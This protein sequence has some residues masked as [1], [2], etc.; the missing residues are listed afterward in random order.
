MTQKILYF[1]ISLAAGIS[2]C[3]EDDFTDLNSFHA[4][5]QSI[6]FG[7]PFRNEKEE[8]INYIFVTDEDIPGLGTIQKSIQCLSEKIAE[9]VPN[10]IVSPLGLTTKEL[11]FLDQLAYGHFVLDK[12]L[13]E[14]CASEALEAAMVHSSF[15][16]D[17]FYN[18]FFEN[19][20]KSD[21]TIIIINAHGEGFPY[22]AGEFQVGDSNFIRMKNIE[23]VLMTC[24]AGNLELS[25]DTKSKIFGTGSK[26]NISS[27]LTLRAFLTDL[28]LESVAAPTSSLEFYE[29]Y[30]NLYY[31]LPLM[32]MVYHASQEPIAGEWTL[33]DFMAYYIDS[34]PAKIIGKIMQ[35]DPLPMS[36]IP[37]YAD[38]GSNIYYGQKSAPW[39]IVNPDTGSQFTK[40]LNDLTSG[41]FGGM[42]LRVALPVWILLR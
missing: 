39:W 4:L 30:R 29:S 16:L 9:E 23:F 20:K 38:K 37:W 10:S 19:I 34:I 25:K 11:S 28:N 42:F 1:L 27:G 6:D 22:K 3:E 8:V 14:I 21:R 24:E 31:Q 17:G 33:R 35:F 32:T 18:R 13:S 40:L 15:I 12:T 41:T 2:F 7:L 36:S 26:G 5:E